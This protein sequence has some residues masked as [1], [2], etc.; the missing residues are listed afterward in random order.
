M[1]STK[2]LILCFAILGLYQ[3]G[4]AQCRSF[5][6]KN[7]LPSMAPYLTGPSFNSAQLN[8]GDQAELKLT[9][10]ANQAYRLMVCSQSV[11]GQVEFKI[12]DENNTVLYDNANDN[13]TQIYD[14]SVAGTQNLTISISVPKSD[15]GVKL[16]PQGCVNIIVGQKES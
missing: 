9:F 2:L 16:V 13:F 10:N 11:L 3:T 5:A 1:R 6:K 4:S 8:P 14:F 15:K 7:C 12:L